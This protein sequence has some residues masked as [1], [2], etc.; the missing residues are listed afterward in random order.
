MHRAVICC[1]AGLLAC[2]TNPPRAHPLP[3]LMDVS[4]DDCTA[5]ILVFDKPPGE[6]TLEEPG[7][8]FINDGCWGGRIFLGIDGQRREL[9]RKE[10]SLPL[11]LGGAYSDGEYRVLVKRGKVFSRVGEP[12]ETELPCQAPQ[13]TTYY[14]TYEVEVRI[15]SRR[16]SWTIHGALDDAEC[17]P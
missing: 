6:A 7:I 12:G 1:L 3:P 14:V 15:R 5:S 11:G 17:G 4:G 10:E 13:A 16:G 8:P 9:T 2:G